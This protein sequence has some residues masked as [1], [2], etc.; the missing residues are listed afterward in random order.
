[1]TVSDL[2]QLLDDVPDHYRVL[3]WDCDS[4]SYIDFESGDLK[5]EWVLSVKESVK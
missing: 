4:Q 5:V 3:K 1:M 2:K